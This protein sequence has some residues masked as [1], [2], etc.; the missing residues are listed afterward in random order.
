MGKTYLYRPQDGPCV[1]AGYLIRYQAVADAAVPEFLELW[2]RSPFYRKWV[3][4]MLRAGAQP[5]INAAEYSSLPL[6]LPS[7][8]EQRAIAATLDS[9]DTAIERVRAER[10]ALQSAKASTADALLTG[11]VRVGVR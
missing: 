7:L 5:N 8:A 1:Y 10:A 6:S 9:V 2:T 11:R 4:S 3:A